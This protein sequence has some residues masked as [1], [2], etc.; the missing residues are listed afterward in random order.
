MAN[1]FLKAL[2]LEDD[3]PEQVPMEENQAEEP[4]EA[5]DKKVPGTG[6]I[7]P[8]SASI[9]VDDVKNDNTPK[10]DITTGGN[11]EGGEDTRVN[12][13]TI[14]DPDYVDP[15]QET[16]PDVPVE[17]ETTE[18]TP[19]GG[20]T[21]P[22]VTEEV[23][24]E[25]EP[26]VESVDTN[27]ADQTPDEPQEEITEDTLI[28]DVEPE[29]VADVTE[30][31]ED[32]AEEDLE[33]LD[34]EA[35]E[36]AETDEEAEEAEDELEELKDANEAWT[37]I[38][39][40]AVQRNV[41]TPELKAGLEAH[42]NRIEASLGDHVRGELASLEAFREDD[43]LYADQA[44][45]SLEGVSDTLERVG[46]RLTNRFSKAF[47]V[48]GDLLSQ[49]KTYSKLKAL[50][51]A[52]LNKIA[53][54]KEPARDLKTGRQTR[55]L[56][57]AGILPTNIATAVATHTKNIESVFNDF[58]PKSL[59]N[60]GKILT[61]ANSTGFRKTDDVKAQIAE[62]RKI[63]LASSYLKP[64][65][66]SGKAF[67]GCVAFRGNDGH[68]VMNGSFARYCSSRQRAGA[69]VWKDLDDVPQRTKLTIKKADAQAA[70]KAIRQHCANMENAQGKLRALEKK[71]NEGINKTLV[72]LQSGY[73]KATVVLNA[74]N[75]P[76][77]YQSAASKMALGEMG[78]FIGPSRQA[79][80]NDIRALRG[81]IE[82]LSQ[83]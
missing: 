63:P 18:E 60:L 42:F 55:A 21:E 20:D 6:A 3:A 26:E 50:A 80:Y 39:R 40:S 5:Q 54:T 51:D 77:R 53:G 4:Q 49:K 24:P 13:N 61:L 47:H 70:L 1:H 79:I 34:E 57:V 14:E 56:T 31:E 82:F 64:E 9:N 52:A 25:T 48:V 2:G 72:V 15:E 44:I 78:W 73:P 11:A 83:Y 43:A 67:L 12:E 66:V 28:S 7:A 19:E 38:M 68:S 69:A 65:W 10:M 75:R 16:A 30:E 45:A 8:G 71:V 74:A 36:E 35:E 29:P 32:E 27:E 46:E 17:P 41:V 59:D 81:V 58:I 76:A 22:E 33:A 62:L 37:I 23:A